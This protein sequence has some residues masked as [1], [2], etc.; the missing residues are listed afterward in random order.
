MRKPV[1]TA[2][3]SW[4]TKG[5]LKK[6]AEGFLVAAQSQALGVNAIKAKIVQSQESLW[7]RLC[8]QKS[9]TVKHIVSEGPKITQTQ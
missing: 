7:C 3:W 9:D 8:N 5:Y 6:E 2:G 1:R 4:L